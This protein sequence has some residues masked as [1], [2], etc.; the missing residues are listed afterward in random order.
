M[1]DKD[2]F[3]RLVAIKINIA[4]EENQSKYHLTS[5]NDKI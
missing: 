1:D 3:K 5:E 2:K 4:E